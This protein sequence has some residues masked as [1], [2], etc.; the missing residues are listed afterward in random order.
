MAIPTIIQAIN[1]PRLF[2][3][4]FKDIS[5]WFTWLVFLRA[6]FAL[7]MD[8]SELA[9]YQQLTG[10]IS[11]PTAPF[12]EGYLICGRR[13]GKSYI[14]ALIAT[15]LACFFDYSQY[16]SPGERGVV[17]VVAAD[18]RQARV[19]LRYVKAFLKI[20]VLKRLVVRETMES[21]DLINGISIEIHT[22]S[23]RS[24]RGYTIVA[25]LGDEV[26]FWRSDESANPD[27]EVINSVLP[28][29]A[30]IPKALLLGLGSPY[31][32]RGVLYEAH[33]DH[34]GKDGSDVLVIQAPTELMNPTINKQIITRAY[35]KDPVA[36]AS[37]YGAQFRTDLQ[38][39]LEQAWIERS[40]MSGC[41][42]LPPQSGKVY[43]SFSDAA[44][45]ARV[46]RDKFTISIGHAEP[47]GTSVLDVIRAI[48][49]P[50]DPSVVVA[51]FAKLLK[52]YGLRT[53]TGDRYSSQWVVEAFAKEGITYLHSERSK[54]E[55]YLEAVSLFASGAVRILD[56]KNL[57]S[58]LI[59]LE[60]KTSRSGR[61]VV[62][63][64]VGAHDDLANSC[65]GVLVNVAI[66]N[67]RIPDDA[68]MEVM[69]RDGVLASSHRNRRFVS[70]FDS[71]QDEAKQPAWQRELGGIT[72]L[73]WD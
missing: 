14:V 47:D 71:A 41:A 11:A 25:F 68:L 7:P 72:K 50:F 45:G 35:E 52:S 58:E 59:L 73:E 53:V 18:R 62:D 70:A 39:L 3:P 20:P 36:A 19:I 28:G 54:S 26:A 48:A 27:R 49:P 66:G 23:F 44:G 9:I 17:M 21:I 31:S 46:G 4:F 63:H 43:A 60:R 5:S 42:E 8:K 22:C 12:R 24:T 37:E 61:D 1:D 16:L 51:E 67:V 40:V 65:A 6:L 38:G 30:T 69:G 55:I 64:P 10:R 34:F 57:I 33:R 29:M 56:N 13:G 2:R 32:M 15:Y